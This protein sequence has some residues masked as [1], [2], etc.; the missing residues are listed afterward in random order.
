MK[1]RL[2]SWTSYSY[3][4][5]NPLSGGCWDLLGGHELREGVE[6]SEGVFA[7]PTPTAHHVDHNGEGRGG[8]VDGGG[9]RRVQR[10]VSAE[11][12]AVRRQGGEIWG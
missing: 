2:A 11:E 10:G 5:H 8:L 1:E 9:G 7:A 6:G 4:H 12:V 3:L